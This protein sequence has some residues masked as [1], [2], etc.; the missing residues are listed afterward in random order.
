MVRQV[1][2]TNG[3]EQTKLMPDSW[4]D[5]VA[6]LWNAILRIAKILEIWTHTSL[7]C[8]PKPEGDGMRPIA[9]ASI[10][11]KTY[12]SCIIKQPRCWSDQWADDS[13]YGDSNIRRTTS[14][15]NFRDTRRKYRRKDINGRWKY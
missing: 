3:I 12:I 15:I 4:W 6:D 8:I 10:L 1:D 2:A 11:W 14:T 7:V 9:I 5:H 13:V